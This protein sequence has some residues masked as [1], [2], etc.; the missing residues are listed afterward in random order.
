MK[1]S[2]RGK[3]K[4]EVEAFEGVEVLLLPV[5]DLSTGP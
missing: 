1:K 2:L 5:F 4:G 3:I